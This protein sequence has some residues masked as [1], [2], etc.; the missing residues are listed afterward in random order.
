M[1]ESKW[2]IFVPTE[3]KPKTKTW[4]V[5]TKEKGKP[6][7]EGGDF[8][9]GVRWF[10]PWRCY[11]FYPTPNTIFEKTCLRDIAA[12]CEEET[13]KQNNGGRAHDH[14]TREGESR[15]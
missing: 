13:T 11:A 14:R 12:F 9:G 6:S 4:E 15:E 1:S 3:P 8:L 10:G 5:W 2:I 7:F